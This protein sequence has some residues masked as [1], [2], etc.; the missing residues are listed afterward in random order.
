MIILILLSLFVS[1]TFASSNDE[2]LCQE[3]LEAHLKVIEASQKQLRSL[4]LNSKLISPYA[5]TQLQLNITNRYESLKKFMTFYE[6]DRSNCG[7]YLV[8]KAVAIYDFTLFGNVALVQSDLRRIIEDFTTFEKY[9]LT[10]FVMSYLK[11][12]SDNYINKI[13]SE[14]AEE[15]TKIPKDLTI[16]ENVGK[17][18]STFNDKL[19]KGAG[20][21]IV[22]V[23][24]FWGFISDNLKWRNGRL[25]NNQIVFNLLKNNLKPLDLIFE[26][27]K[28]LLSNYTIPGHWGHIAIWLGTKKELMDLG[29][30][31]QAY[32]APFKAQVLAGKQILEIR[33]KGID[34][35]SLNDFINLDEIAVTRV[36]NALDNAEYIF[37]ELALQTDK[38]YDFQFDAHTLSKITCSELVAFSYGNIAW[39]QSKTLFQTIIRPDDIAVVTTKKNAP[40]KFILYLK[41]NKDKSFNNMSFANWK[42]LYQSKSKITYPD[43]NQAAALVR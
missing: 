11:Y 3:R 24:K 29:V 4:A 5:I 6:D 32:F 37:N 17:N 38:K 22:N 25:Q 18:V 26:E 42:D 43:L 13:Q 23:A 12:T 28:F 27:K 35:V 41:G 16:K 10:N 20:A 39:P 34:Y 8:S 33:K 40:A 7:S 21:I 15:G 9:D 31:D 1:Q 30:W 14:I 19:I 36:S 2:Q